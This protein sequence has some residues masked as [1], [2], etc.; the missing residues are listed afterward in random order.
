MVFL[1][2]L[3]PG[4]TWT[5]IKWI[6]FHQHEF[7]EA[8][9][10]LPT[11][12]KNF[13]G[14]VTN[15]PG[16]RATLLS[17]RVL[18]IFWK[19][20]PSKQQWRIALGYFLVQNT[21]SKLL[22]F[23]LASWVGDEPE[24]PLCQFNGFIFQNCAVHAGNMRGKQT[25]IKPHSWKTCNTY[26]KNATNLA[27]QLGTVFQNQKGTHSHNILSRSTTTKKTEDIIHQPVFFPKFP[28][29]FFPRGFHNPL[30][31]S[32]LWTPESN[33]IGTEPNVNQCRCLVVQVGDFSQNSNRHKLGV[34]PKNRGI[35]PPKWMVVYKGKPYETWDD[36]GG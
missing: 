19:P 2:E 4:L 6:I 25:W 16:R 13:W 15:S 31:K 22:C 20:S 21:Y 28:K 29:I 26:S 32:R 34:N 30:L 24:L 36:L 8:N 33:G 12:K 23:P 3:P 9:S 18:N 17:C 11:I 1:A 10:F 7:P 27:I 35:L 5:S 14:E